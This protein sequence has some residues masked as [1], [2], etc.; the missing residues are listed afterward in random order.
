MT[1]SNDKLGNTREI[2]TTLFSTL[3]IFP[4]SPRAWNWSWAQNSAGLSAS[5]QARSQSREPIFLCGSRRNRL[6]QL[7][8][9]RY[10]FEA[11]SLLFQSPFLSLHDHT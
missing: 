10:I 11:I 3:W 6:W 7:A 1:Q 8:L 2:V 9:V 5:H 4:A